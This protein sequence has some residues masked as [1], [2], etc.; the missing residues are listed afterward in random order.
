MNEDYAKACMYLTCMAYEDT[1][2][3]YSSALGIDYW[4][5]EYDDGSTVFDHVK[6]DG[7]K[8]LV[9]QTVLCSRAS[10]LGIAQSEERL[11]ELNAIAHEICS[12]CGLPFED[13][14]KALAD[15]ELSQMVYGALVSAMA[16]DDE[17]ILGK[18]DKADYLSHIQYLFVPFDA[19]SEAPELKTGFQSLL[20]TLSGFSGD[21][22]QAAGLNSEVNCGEIGLSELEGGLLEAALSLPEGGTSSVIETEIGL[23]VLRREKGSD[24]EEYLKACAQ[25]LY[26]AREAAFQSDYEK[27]FRETEYTI[28]AAFWDSLTPP[29]N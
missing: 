9:M 20:E 21:Y 10:S 25:A 7:F 23:F 3:Y 4:T 26:S 11:S 1:V 6:A 18:I 5:L 13:V 27:L 29:K 22:E 2:S 17:S 15:R 14:F 28:D 12:E 24:E 8:A 16:V 19:Y